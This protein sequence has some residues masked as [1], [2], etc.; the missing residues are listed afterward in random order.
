[1][2]TWTDGGVTW[3]A[4]GATANNATGLGGRPLVQPNGTVVVPFEGASMQAY[5][6][7]DGVA[8]LE[9][10]GQDF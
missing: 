3:G 1:M 6:Q 7:P 8:S 5:V 10:I 9:R 2:S 4:A